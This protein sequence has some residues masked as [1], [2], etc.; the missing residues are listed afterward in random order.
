MWPTTTSP[1][2][3]TLT[4]T[5]AGLTRLTLG[6]HGAVALAAVVTFAP[7]CA[8]LAAPEPTAATD[9]KS[10][11]LI[12]TIH[13]DSGA[14]PRLLRLARADYQIDGKPAVSLVPAR[15]SGPIPASAISSS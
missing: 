8:R 5:S 15:G 13:N 11:S 1:G 14:R 6:L 12:L 7:G 9:G 2:A 10:P 3:D 4:R